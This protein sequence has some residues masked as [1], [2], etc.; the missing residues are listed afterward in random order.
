MGPE[1]KEHEP[2]PSGA[3]ADALAGP[4]GLDA[5]HVNAMTDHSHEIER[6]QAENTRLVAENE[7]LG[8]ENA[9]TGTE[10]ARLHKL[11]ARQDGTI[12]FLAEQCAMVSAALKTNEERQIPLDPVLG[13]KESVTI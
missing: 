9:R 2:T 6:L 13:R 11:F 5:E 1:G 8:A 12:A 4:V 3:A 10:N 7:R